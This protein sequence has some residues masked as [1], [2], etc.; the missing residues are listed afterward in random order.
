[1]AIQLG[2]RFCK[3]IQK[4]D[5]YITADGHKRGKIGKSSLFVVELIT[6]KAEVWNCCFCENHV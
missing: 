6:E 3:N 5:S 1:M 4:E 2:D